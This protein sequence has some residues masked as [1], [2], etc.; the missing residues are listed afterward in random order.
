MPQPWQIT[1]ARAFQTQGI[2][3]LSSAFTVG[4]STVSIHETWLLGLQERA[5]EA[6]D[7]ANTLD[8]TDGVLRTEYDF[9]RQMNVAIA[10]RLDS[11]VADEDPLQR[12]VDQIREAPNSRAAIDERT[13]KTIACWLKINA[14]RAAAVP[15]QPAV[16]VRG[17]AS[18]VYQTRWVDL[19]DKR[20]MRENAAGDW[21]GASSSL[22][23][24]D[25]QLDRL[26]K[27]WYQAWSSEFPAGTAEGDALA[28]V[29]TESG[30]AAP[31][32]LEIAAVVQQG[33]SL[34]VTYVPGS[35]AHATVLNLEYFV[36]GVNG[37]FQTVTAD[38]AAG[39]II[40]PFT[41]GQI[42]RLRTDVGNSRDHSELSPE[43]VVTIS[44]PV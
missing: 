35:G 26:N 37:D 15:A 14:A 13:L 36:E 28:G 3:A 42:V 11:E 32:V 1:Q 18:A 20:Q 33:L 2:W 31:Q 43:Q 16:L 6:E 23:A 17:T 8:T 30:T 27:A 22:R 4:G 41:Q 12:D 21:R 24:A 39:N 9:F 29:D 7:Y 44:A 40:G 25:R 10:G 38:I 19:Q 5:V 34:R